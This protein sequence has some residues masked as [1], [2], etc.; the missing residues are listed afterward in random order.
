MRGGGMPCGNM[1]RG[2]KVAMGAGKLEGGAECGLGSGGY[3]KLFVRRRQHGDG[4]GRGGRGGRRQ[5]LG[6][7]GAQRLG[8]IG[9]GERD[10]GAAEALAARRVDGEAHV[11]DGAARRRVRARAERLDV[12]VRRPPRQVAQREHGHDAS[13]ARRAQP[14]ATTAAAGG[15]QTR[16]ARAA[17]TRL[18]AARHSRRHVARLAAKRRQRRL[19]AAAALA[20]R[21]SARARA[22]R[23]RPRADASDP[24]FFKMRKFLG[25]LQSF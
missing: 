4:D 24:A 3:R 16:R 23:P 19:Q 9:R 17:P 1:L 18:K 10:G 2:A 5:V 12:G 14:P 11:G 25:L 6:E 22:C 13:R 15:E 7:R 21:V 8:Q 20:R